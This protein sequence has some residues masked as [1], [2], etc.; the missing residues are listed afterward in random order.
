MRFFTDGSINIA[1][2]ILSA[3]ILTTPLS[4]IVMD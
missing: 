1:I 4:M 2:L 3:M